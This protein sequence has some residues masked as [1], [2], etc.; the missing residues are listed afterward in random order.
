M[1]SRQ[2]MLAMEQEN[3]KKKNFDGSKAN[4]QK[5]QN[6]L[7]SI[8]CAIQYLAFNSLSYT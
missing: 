5:C 3:I 7:P 8:F 1:A 4:R 6:F 2:C